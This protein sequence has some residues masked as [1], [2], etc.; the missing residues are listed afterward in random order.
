MRRTMAVVLAISCSS[1]CEQGT[2]PPAGPPG[3]WL[4]IPSACKYVLESVNSGTDWVLNK[5]Q[6][7][8]TKV[9]E[10]HPLGDAGPLGA[11]FQIAVTNG[12]ESFETTAKDVPCDEYGI[13]TEA[14]VAKLHDAVEEIKAKIKQLQN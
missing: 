9:S 10:V 11:D 12:T 4:G 14:S 5:N 8:V 1:G 6:V 2:T 7:Q 13:P 3:G